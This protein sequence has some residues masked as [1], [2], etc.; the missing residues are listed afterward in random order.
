[1]L[2]VIVTTGIKNSFGVSSSFVKNGPQCGREGKRLEKKQRKKLSHSPHIL[3]KTELKLVDS[4]IIY[5]HHRPFQSSKEV[6]REKKECEQ[7]NQID[8]QFCQL[9]RSVV[10]E[11]TS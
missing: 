2:F 11:H 8:G 1:M 4:S 5:F 6:K 9:V 7:K 10:M 3:R